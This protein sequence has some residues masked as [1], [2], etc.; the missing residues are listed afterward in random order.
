MTGRANLPYFNRKRRIW[1]T[2]AGYIAMT[3]W[4][5][6]KIVDAKGQFYVH[7]NIGRNSDAL[8]TVLMF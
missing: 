7:C 4:M 2:G 8:N 1:G 3:A 5:S 6:M